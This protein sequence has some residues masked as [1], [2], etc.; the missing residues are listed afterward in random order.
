MYEEGLIT[1]SPEYTDV[2]TFDFVEG[3]K[4]ALKEPEYVI[5]PLSLSRKLF[6]NESAVGKQLIG[7]SGNSTV[8]AVY[9]DFPSNSVVDNYIY[10]A[11]PE[12]ENKN[13]WNN[14]NYHVYI[15]VDDAAN[16]PFLFENFKQHLLSVCFRM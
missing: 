12:D 3:T 5:I 8:G 14:W 15:R 2:F 1:V 11:I 6:G 13:N 7:R 9:R 4:D 10:F 16:V